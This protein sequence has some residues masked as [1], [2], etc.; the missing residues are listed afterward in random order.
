MKTRPQIL[1]PKVR[2]SSD[3]RASRHGRTFPPTD[4]NYQSSQ[5]AGTCGTPVK[6]NRPAFVEISNRYFAGE[7][8]RDFLADSGVF[9]TLIV[10]GMF[11]IV[12]GCEA[13]ATLIQ[14]L[15]VL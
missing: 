8:T 9:A 12:N 5:L 14:R 3:L 6:F 7:A 11:P 10:A 1:D 15:G 2:S 4:H 13:I